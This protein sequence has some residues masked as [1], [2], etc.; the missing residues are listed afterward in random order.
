MAGALG[1]KETAA[2]P[3]DEHEGGVNRP[4][5]LWF[6]FGMCA[7]GLASDFLA[8]ALLVSG[9]ITIFQRDVIGSV[10]YLAVTIITVRV[11]VIARSLHFVR[12][13]VL[14]SIGLVVL[15]QVF[16]L[17][18]DIPGPDQ[19]LILSKQ[20][21]LPVRVEQLLFPI[22]YTVFIGS[23][24]A[25]LVEG[26]MARRQLVRERQTLADNI[27]R[28]RQAEAELLHAKQGLEQ[29]V[30][31]RTAELEEELRERQSAEKAL[32]ASESRLKAVFENYGLGIFT[33]DRRGRLQQ[34]NKRWA[35]LM[36]V[37]VTQ[38][39][40]MDLPPL[41]HPG[42]SKAVMALVDEIFDGTKESIEVAMRVQRRNGS[43][44]WSRL[45]ASVMEYRAGRPWVMLGVMADITDV[46]EAQVRR[47]ESARLLEAVISSAPMV[48]WSIDKEG[49]FTLSE[50]SG[51]ASIGLKSG[52][53]VG[54]SIWQL[55]ADS[56]EILRQAREAL[57]GR[58]T[59]QLSSTGGL[60]FRSTYSPLRGVDGDISGAI[61]VAIDVTK[62][63][64]LESQ[65]RRKQKMEA[66]GTLASG[67]AHDFNNILYAISGF[68]TLLKRRNSGDPDALDYLGEIENAVNRAANLVERILAF[69]AR[70]E[71]P[72][73]AVDFG[74][75]V[76]NVARL[77]RGSILPNIELR[78]DVAPDLP[79]VMGDPSQIEQMLLN[80]A[81]N[82]QHAMA[83]QGGVLSVSLDIA[84]IEPGGPHSDRLLPGDYLRCVVSDTGV[85]ISRDQ[86]EQIFEP[87]F[88][89]KPVGQGTGLGMAIVDNVVRTHGGIVAVD[90]AEG[91]GTTFTIYLPAIDPA[92]PMPGEF[93]HPVPRLEDIPPQHVLFVDDES[94][95]CMFAELLFEGTPHRVTTCRNGEDALAA[96]EADPDDFDVVL[97]DQY[98]PGLSG[99]ALC[100]LLHAIRPGLPVVVCSG[101]DSVS[102]REEAASAGAV[103]FLKKPISIDKLTSVMSMY[104]FGDAAGGNRS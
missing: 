95:V 62:E 14:L 31:E 44:L 94:A 15:S 75:E 100:R 18:E 22:G 7:L 59:T 102:D 89:T 33:V 11:A 48:I 84:A 53:V 76:Q 72:F 63:T 97:V 54:K 4:R 68:N 79:P 99:T 82:A 60:M 70:R 5:L 37:D 67:I 23:C 36:E 17:I 88:T 38:A 77:L 43:T 73:E 71:R 34:W 78:V 49:Q 41:I 103:D 8:R 6:I 25:A 101:L 29:A 40:D 9:Q 21:P 1:G 55:Y 87:F 24:L 27:E 20:I 12:R 61:G 66:I 65:M 96:F 28:R 52:E 30:Q 74:A 10:L 2:I 81:T 16:N 104:A 35:D 92:A 26:E 85:G 46:H 64:Q 98:M 58:G 57:A 39:Q 3:D 90:S 80:L 86:L 83:E 42:D 51:L 19:L 13:A 32:R 50:G 47:T 45:T 93:A 56:P 69:S 91:L